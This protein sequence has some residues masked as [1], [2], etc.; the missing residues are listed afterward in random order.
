MAW[1]LPWAS[2]NRCEERMKQPIIMLTDK[3]KKLHKERKPLLRLGERGDPSIITSASRC[4]HLIVIIGVLAA[5]TS[6]A[7]IGIFVEVV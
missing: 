7:T 5:K 3:I 4:Q 1:A 2:P 6:M